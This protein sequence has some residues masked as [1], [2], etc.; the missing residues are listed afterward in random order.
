MSYFYEK[1]AACHLEML[2]GNAYKT[3]YP[4]IGD[5]VIPDPFKAQSNYVSNYMKADYADDVIDIDGRSLVSLYR[6]F[7]VNE[8]VDTE[9]DYKLIAEK[10]TMVTGI[11]FRPNSLILVSRLITREQIIMFPQ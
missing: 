8:I 4:Y 10:T 7:I 9:E 3:Y 1:E 11:F 5:F 6:P 2:Y